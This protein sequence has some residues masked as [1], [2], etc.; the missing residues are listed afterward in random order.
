[1]QY[2]IK[3]KESYYFLARYKYNKNDEERVKILDKR[4]IKENRNK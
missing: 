4:F 2:G 1:M 3:K